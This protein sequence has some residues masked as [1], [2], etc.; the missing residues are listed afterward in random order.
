[1]ALAGI[2]AGTI[3]VGIPGAGDIWLKPYFWVL[4][5]VLLF[6]VGVYLR[7]KN[8]PGTMLA[9]NARLLG[10]AIGMAL[11]VAIPLAAGVPVHF[12]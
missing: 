4:L 2:A 11:M 9:M 10:S 5:T 1:M 8:A 3:L 6:D 7:W 12:F